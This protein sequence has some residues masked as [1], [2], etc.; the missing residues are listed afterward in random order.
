MDGSI[1]PLRR[2]VVAGALALSLGCGPALAGPLDGLTDLFSDSESRLTTWIAN[3]TERVRMSDWDYLDLQTRGAAEQSAPNQH[4]VALSQVDVA[5][6]LE[7]VKARSGKDVVALFEPDEVSRLSRAIAGTF[8]KARPDQ[9]LVFVS[10][11]RHKVL[12]SFGQKLT[13]TG[14]VFYAEG[15]LQLIVGVQLSDALLGLRPGTQPMRSLDPGS[16][17]KAAAKVD[18]VEAP[19]PGVT[20]VRNDWVAL[21]LDATP[22]PATGSEPG[23]AAATAAIAPAA[24]SGT[25]ASR[26]DAEVERHFNQQESR[27]LLLKRMRDQGL[28]SEEEYQAKRAEAL[29]N[30]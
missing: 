29:K 18:L 14:R 2:L 11:A 19:Q 25:P 17:S 1:L 27:L 26:L 12:G 16:R 4:P 6:A 20:R 13:T 3:P 30:L 15:T 22:G 21:R 8:G 9:D 28:I 10:T 5:H 24:P 23:P 7:R